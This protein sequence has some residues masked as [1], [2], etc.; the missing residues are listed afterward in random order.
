[1]PALMVEAP[2]SR[3][4]VGMVVVDMARNMDR[5]RADG[6]VSALR[7]AGP[8]GRGGALEDGVQGQHQLEHGPARTNRPASSPVAAH[9]RRRPCTLAADGG[10]GPCRGVPA[11]ASVVEL[12]GSSADPASAAHPANRRKEGTDSARSLSAQMPI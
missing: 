12:E 4:T 3:M 5:W 11:C 9:V 2:L 7:N 6:E 10:P 1:M 8:A